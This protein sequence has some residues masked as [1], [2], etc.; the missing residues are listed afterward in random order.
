MAVDARAGLGKEPGD[1]CS[2]VWLFDIVINVNHV[3]MVAKSLD[4]VDS[5]LQLRFRQLHL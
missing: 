5:L 1:T 3:L 4:E 2:Q